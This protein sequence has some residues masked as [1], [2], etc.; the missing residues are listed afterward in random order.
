MLDNSPFFYK[1]SIDEDKRKEAERL[2]DNYDVSSAWLIF[3][4]MRVKKFRENI[5]ETIKKIYSDVK[6][7]ATI[8]DNLYSDDESWFFKKENT[9]EFIIK[10]IDF[11]DKKYREL[12][13]NQKYYSKCKEYNASIEKFEEYVQSVKNCK[14]NGE[15]VKYD[16]DFV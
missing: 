2:L 9:K 4:N 12:T 10:L 6:L 7:D 3:Y 15:P 16:I 14:I 8:D 11:Y 13:L 1:I 5:F